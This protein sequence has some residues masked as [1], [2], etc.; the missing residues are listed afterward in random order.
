MT[1]EAL[2]ELMGLVGV[3][4][5][6]AGLHQLWLAREEILF[7]LERFLRIFTSALR[8]Q[9][10]GGTIDNSSAP[11]RQPELRTLHLVGGI[12]LLALGS[13]LV[14]ASLALFFV[15]RS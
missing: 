5:F 15:S 13:F 2:L 12:G 10:A 14:F 11:Q 6:L 7:W 3:I 4:V 9:E 1:R 8:K